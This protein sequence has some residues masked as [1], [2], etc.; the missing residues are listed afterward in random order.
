MQRDEKSD[1]T[2]DPADD[3]KKIVIWQDDLKSTE[4]IQVQNIREEN[5]VQTVHHIVVP[6]EV[7][8]EGT[9][10]KMEEGHEKIEFIVS[11]EMPSIS[12]AVCQEVNS[13]RC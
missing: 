3:A 1:F 10:L 7:W 5:Q 13:Q 4:M 8:A 2:T 6:P 11:S 12:E 9:V